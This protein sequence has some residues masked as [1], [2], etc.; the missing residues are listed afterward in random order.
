MIGYGGSRGGGKSGALR[1]LAI[2]R[3]VQHPGT[4]GLIF[5][6]VYEDVKEN[7][8]EK[9]LQEWPELRECYNISGKELVIP[10]GGAPSR[11]IFG[12]AENIDDIARKYQGPEFM[13]IFVDQAEQLTEKEIKL[14]KLANRWPGIPDHQCK[15]VLFFNPGGVGLQYFKR[16]FSEN[17]FEKNEIPEDHAFVQAYGWDNIEWCATALADD[18][19][20]WDDFYNWSNE[21]RYEYFITRS[22]YGRELN[23]LPDSLRI[24]HLL[25]S[26]DTFAGQYFSNYDQ[27]RVVI[28]PN[29]VEQLIKPWW[30]RWLSMDWGFQ[31]DS[32]IKWWAK[33]TVTPEEAAELLNLKTPWKESREVVVTWQEMVVNQM[34][35]KA[36]A[37]TICAKTGTHKLSRFFLSPDAFAKRTSA[38]TIADGIGEVMRRYGHPSPEPADNDR[39]GGW[40]LMYNL[41]EEDRWVISS[42]CRELVNAIPMLFRDEKNLED[43]KKSSTKADDVA[44][45]A[46]YGLKS[47]MESRPMPRSMQIEEAVRNIESPIGK[48]VTFIQMTNRDKKS[49][50]LQTRNRKGVVLA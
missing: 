43:V 1:R 19:L 22:Q 47:M 6:R 28:S 41:L 2:A 27:N 50:Y 4:W 29:K 20:G 45:D 13:D 36:L 44:D 49:V 23:A 10:T 18:G 40:R 16:I 5:R 32:A 34:A 7:H 17:R 46:R 3:R 31:H 42:N 11:I 26:M 8:I 15:M 35:E 37:E 21:Q 33:G 39:V 48:M 38:H 9:F 30:P 12:Y 24:G 14:L 25:G